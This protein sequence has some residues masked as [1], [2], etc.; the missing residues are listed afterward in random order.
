MGNPLINC[1]RDTDGRWFWLI[2]LEGDRHWPD[3]CRA[4][5]HPEWIDDE[6]FA[7]LMP[8]RDHFR[9]LIGLLDEIFATKTREEWGVDVRPRE[10][11]GGRRCRPSTS[12]SPTSSSSPP[13]G[14][15]E[16]PDGAEHRDDGRHT[17]RLRRARP[18][19]RAPCRPASASTPTR[20]SPS[21]A[22]DRAAVDHLRADGVVL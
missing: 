11:C 17:G 8:R 9:E 16:V 4:V 5:G 12:C 21:S 19:R 18:G 22:D 13:A 2:G 15:V 10:T 20:S 1:Y 7:T 3:L 14:F 6:R